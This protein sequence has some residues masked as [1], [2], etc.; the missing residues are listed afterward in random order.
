[1]RADRE[2]T[3]H[4]FQKWLKDTNKILMITALVSVYIQTAVPAFIFRKGIVFQIFDVDT[5]SIHR[6]SL[7]YLVVKIKKLYAKYSKDP[8]WSS[9]PD[10]I[11]ESKYAVNNIVKQLANTI[12]YCVGHNNPPMIARL[13]KYTDFLMSQD[14]LYLKEEWTMFRPLSGNKLIQE[15]NTELTEVVKKNEQ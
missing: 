9:L 1:M 14:R 10:L 7:E 2:T 6:Q 12:M 13:Q 15:V 3:F 11:D 4:N 8:L 5:K